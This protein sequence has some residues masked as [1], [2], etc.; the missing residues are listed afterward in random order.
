MARL[1][2]LA[3]QDPS[4]TSRP[5]GPPAQPLNL[6][7]SITEYFVLNANL[8]SS[9]CML[10]QWS[11]SNNEVNAV[12][13]PKSSCKCLGVKVGTTR[14][15]QESKKHRR[16]LAMGTR[17][18]RSEAALPE[19]GKLQSETQ[20]MNSDSSRASFLAR[21]PRQSPGPPLRGLPFRGARAV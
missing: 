6:C 14:R 2:R 8:V 19:S 10:L 20:V 7:P 18:V 5:V 16:W 12:L 17:Q 3:C 15:R 1:R 21:H 4:L 9:T 13:I 11:G